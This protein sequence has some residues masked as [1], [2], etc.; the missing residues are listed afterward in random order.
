VL[1]SLLTCAEPYLVE[2][3]GESLKL[4]SLADVQ[5]ALNAQFDRAALSCKASET[6]AAALSRSQMINACMSEIADEITKSGFRQF[7]QPTASQRL[8]F[9]DRGG[10]DIEWQVSWEQDCLRYEIRS[11][12]FYDK[13]HYIVRN[14]SNEIYLR[15]YLIDFQA[16]IEDVLRSMALTLSRHLDHRP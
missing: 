15:K 8:V 4:T 9:R 10:L 13:G 2:R 3:I 5:A 12:L 6:S 14:S 11:P 7:D 1:F 16:K